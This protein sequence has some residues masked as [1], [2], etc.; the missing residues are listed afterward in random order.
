MTPA[1]SRNHSPVVQCSPNFRLHLHNR[2]DIGA[3]Q[4]ELNAQVTSNSG[5]LVAIASELTEI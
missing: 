1:A 2:E 5:N 4:V 3:N